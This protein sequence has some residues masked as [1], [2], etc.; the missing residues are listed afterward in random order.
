MDDADKMRKVRTPLF[1][2]YSEVRSLLPVLDGVEKGDVL[3]LVKEILEH[4]GTPQD[5]VDWSDPDTWIGERL[6]GERQRLARAIWERSRK[7][8]NPRHM[9]G[10]Y[11]FIYGY[12]LL[13]PGAAGNYTLTERGKAFLRGDA[14]VVREIDQ[15]EGIPELLAILATKTRAKRADLL[16]EWGEFLRAYSRYGTDSTIKDTLRRRLVNVVE[17]GLATREGNTFDVTADGAAYAVDALL[18]TAEPRNLVLREINV[19]NTMQMDLLRERLGG[20]SPQRFERLVGD[21]LESMGYEDVEVVGQAG[22]R[23]IDVVGMVQVG[24]TAVREVVQ[25][26][27]RKNNVNRKVVDQLRGALP[28]H[29]AIRGT[30]ITLSRFTSGCEKAALF[31]GAA[32]ITLIDGD[33]LI[34]LL[35]EHEIAV[36]RREAHL[37]EIDE[38]Y[39]APLAAEA[40]GGLED[41]EGGVEP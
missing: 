30:L 19:Y 8:V 37:V 6:T 29:Q 38:D 25:V 24:I 32:P 27:R 16:P 35:I 7:T 21:L 3:E 14:P 18:S 34:Q 36:T 4:A 22:D 9:Y 31:P 11:L 33:R 20:M 12:D 2:L 15:L 23:G 1:P 10:S 39:F 41:H 5:P 28:Y 13:A 17:R 26:K 40:P